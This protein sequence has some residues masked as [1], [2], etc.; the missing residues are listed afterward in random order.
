MSSVEHEEMARGIPGNFIDRAPQGRDLQQM[1]MKPVD[2]EIG[3]AFSKE[4]DDGID[5]VSFNELRREFESFALRD[6]LF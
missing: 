5:F 6:R 1:R 2:E 4:T 3:L